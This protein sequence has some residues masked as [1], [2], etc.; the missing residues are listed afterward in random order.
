[1]HKF[2]KPNT[3][4]IIWLSILALLLL[5]KVW[6]LNGYPGP[7]QNN[8]KGGNAR[9]IFTSCFHDNSCKLTSKQ[10]NISILL[11]DSL[12]ESMKDIFYNKFAPDV[13]ILSLTGC[14]FIPVELKYKSSIPVTSMCQNHYNK[15]LSKVNSLSSSSI[16]IYNRYLPK[17]TMETSNYLTFLTSLQQ[18]G[19]KIKVIG[20]PI[21]IIKQ[22]SSYSTLIFSRAIRTPNSIPKSGFSM[23]SIDNN[24]KLQIAINS[25]NNPNITYLNTASIICPRYPCKL[26]D[27]L[28]N[29]IYTDN[30]HLSYFGNNKLLIRF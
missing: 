12:A 26:N 3:F 27:N 4:F 7:F 17:T 28:G 2:T 6:I 15:S 11:G 23:Q 10:E 29:S 16:Y 19:N 1:M 25:L 13:Q 8:L 9:F 22:Y 30:T 18:N 24:R 21:E 14:S 5:T 20:Q